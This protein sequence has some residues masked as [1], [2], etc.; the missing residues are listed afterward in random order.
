MVGDDDERALV[1]AIEEALSEDEPRLDRLPE[2]NLVRQDE[3]VDGV[4]EDPGDDLDL[5]L[6]DL[7][8]A[9]HQRCATAG[10]R[11]LEVQ[12]VE[13]ATAKFE[14]ARRVDDPMPQGIKDPFEVLRGI[15]GRRPPRS[16]S[17]CAS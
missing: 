15:A 11:A 7:H 8:L 14:L 5:M 10:E 17:S 6:V 13:K 16:G 9:G 3:P 4:L 2:A 12:L 1:S